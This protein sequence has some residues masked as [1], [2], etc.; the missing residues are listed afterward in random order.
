MADSRSGCMESSGIR[1]KGADKFSIAV[2]VDF[3]KFLGY[4]R[5]VIKSDGE[6]SILALVTAVIQKMPGEDNVKRITSKV[7]PVGSH[8][9]NGRAEVCVQLMQGMA[10]T[11]KLAVEQKYKTVV[12]PNSSILPWIVRHAGYVY[13]RFQVKKNG[14]TPYEE[15]TMRTFQNPLMAFGEVVL[16]RE[17][18]DRKQ[19]LAI[20]WDKGCWLGRAGDTGDHIVGGA[21]GIIKDRAI[22]RL[23]SDTERWDKTFYQNMKWLPWATTEEE[24]NLVGEE[25]TPTASCRAC[26][27]GSY[28]GQHNKR[29]RARLEER[30]KI[31][32]HQKELTLPVP[33]SSS[34][35]ASSSAP[36][37]MAPPPA[38]TQQE[39]KQDEPNQPTNLPSC[40]AATSADKT[41]SAEEEE[42]PMAKRVRFTHKQTPQQTQE[43]AP[44]ELESLN[45]P[46]SMQINLVKA[47]TNDEPD[48]EMEWTAEENLQ[49]QNRLKEIGTWKEFN[50]FNVVKKEP[51]MKVMT[52][53]W[54]DK[55]EK[56]RLCVRGYE[57]KLYD[58][59][60]LYTP[61][62]FPASMSLLLTIAA[63]EDLAAQRFDVCRA[64]LHTPAKVPTFIYPPAEAEAVEGEVWSLNV[65]AYGLEEAMADFDDHFSEACMKLPHPFRRAKGDPTVFTCNT[66]SVVFSRHVDDGLAVGKQEDLDIFFKELSDEFAIKIF[67]PIGKKEQLHLGIHVSRQEYG[68][69]LRSKEVLL[70]EMLEIYDLSTCVPVLVPGTKAE[71]RN[72]NETLITDAE[73]CKKYRTAVG[74]ALFY[75]HRRPDA[76]FQTKECARTVKKPTE[77][78]E[79][80]LK[81]LLKYYAGTRDLRQQLRPVKK[82]SYVVSTDTD[83][84]WAGDR[85]D[86][87]STTGV[88]VSVNRAQVLS[89]SRTQ[90][91]PALSVAEAELNSILS[92]ACETLGLKMLLEETGRSAFA[93]I[94]S[95]SSAGISIASRLGQGRLKHLEIKQ[96]AVQDWVRKGL[97]KMTKVDTAHNHADILTKNLP[98]KLHDYHREALGMRPSGAEPRVSGAGKINLVTPTNG[99]DKVVKGLKTCFTGLLVILTQ[100]EATSPEVI[101]RCEDT[102][103]WSYVAAFFT[104]VACLFAWMW[105]TEVSSTTRT[106]RPEVEGGV[107]SPTGLRATSSAC[108]AGVPTDAAGVHTCPHEDGHRPGAPD[109]RRAEGVAARVCTA[110]HRCQEGPRAA[111]GQHRAPIRHAECDYGHEPT[112]PTRQRTPCPHDQLR[113]GRQSPALHRGIPP[114]PSRE[115]RCGQ[116]RLEP[117]VR[118]YV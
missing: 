54:V 11:F 18:G 60:R 102:S 33:Y 69:D 115:L 86:R 27:L 2:V 22:K 87:K 10:R 12:T 81:R 103:S 50:A 39:K 31:R 66:N 4:P 44:M 106:R 25:W 63:S 37:K 93:A 9:S 114:F 59:N 89:F 6:S 79:S 57:R 1:A 20:I 77:E 32:A 43:S 52:L 71:S 113:V 53:V 101:L 5:I 112:H 34:R 7:S 14:R 75:G 65:V 13:S 104:A 74:K 116:S 82:K 38:E 56:S 64:F 107:I 105:W 68:F 51:G 58:V 109:N 118:F 95:D 45:D 94:R 40:A 24:L 16:M 98:H 72:T 70:D 117:L 96:L 23:A 21:T 62:P 17:P 90:Q 108:G 26:E 78:D 47:E 35:A 92:G 99:F 3:L 100:S 29:C 42:A 41:R 85:V 49:Y 73:C 111:P 83:S 67:D 19:K 55:P 46:I 76:Q 48:A 15:L 84:D 30:Q 110:S 88:A 28:G 80:R 91:T 8:S 97:I 61:T 36:S